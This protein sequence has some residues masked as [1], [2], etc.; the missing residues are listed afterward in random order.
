LQEQ[1]VGPL[2]LYVGSRELAVG[3]CHLGLGSSNTIEGDFE[4]WTVSRVIGE[5][6]KS[7]KVEDGRQ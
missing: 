7:K 5:E 1:E 2:V 6:T 4:S 3:G